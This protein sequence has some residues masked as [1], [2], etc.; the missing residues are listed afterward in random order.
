MATRKPLV[1]IGG[2]IR[3]LPNGDTVAGS[4]GGGGSDVAKLFII[5]ALQAGSG[6]PRWYPD[7]SITIS[8]VYFSLGTAGSAVIDVLKNGA[9]IFS[10]E[11]PTTVSENKS[12]VISV[13][14]AVDPTDY[15]TVSVLTAGGQNATVCV[16]YS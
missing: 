8:S 3:E 14:V 11:K 16:V 15:L 4:A 7:R 6:G 1:L 13:S 5:G 12:S 9:S 2:S 10:G